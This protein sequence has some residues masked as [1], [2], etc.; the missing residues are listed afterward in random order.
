MGSQSTPEKR[1]LHPIMADELISRTTRGL[2]RS[3]MTA[4]TVGAIASA[5]QDEGFVPDPDCGYQDGSIRRQTTQE[6]LDAIDWSD[7]GQVRR[8]L[9]V[10]AAYAR[11]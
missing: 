6:Y 10:R 8:A 2:F 7:P 4:S 5:F 11:P 3:L 1:T 9:R